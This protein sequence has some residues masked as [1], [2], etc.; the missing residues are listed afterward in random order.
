MVSLLM[1]D[2]LLCVFHQSPE[3]YLQKKHKNHGVSGTSFIRET[4]RRLDR[5]VSGVSWQEGYSN[6]HSLH[7]WWAKKHLRT[8]SRTWRRVPV[9]SDANRTWIWGLS[10][11]TDMNQHINTKQNFRNS[12]QHFKLF[13]F[14]SLS[15]DKTIRDRCE[16]TAST[17]MNNSCNVFLTQLPLMMVIPQSSLMIIFS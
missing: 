14:T 2:G 7:L 11:N 1:P 16:E 6:N 13:Q 5:L 17:D 8:L 10:W 12:N 9:Q 3:I 4:Q 15:K